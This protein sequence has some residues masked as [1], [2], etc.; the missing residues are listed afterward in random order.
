MQPYITANNYVYPPGKPIPWD[1]YYKYPN[2]QF[3]GQTLNTFVRPEPTRP[4]YYRNYIAPDYLTLYLNER[5]W[6]EIIRQSVV[7]KLD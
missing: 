4:Y 2:K 1:I 5:P 3:L 7:D 6:Q